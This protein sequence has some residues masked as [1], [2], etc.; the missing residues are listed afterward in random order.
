MVTG[1]SLR[2][3]T[4][5]FSDVSRTVSPL[6]AL[7]IDVLPGKLTSVLGKSGC[8]KTTLLRI[9]GGL[10]KPDEGKV[11][12]FNEEGGSVR[13][14]EIS[15]VFQDPRLL[16]WKTV[17]ENLSLSIRHLSQ[18]EQEKRIFEALELVQL[19]DVSSLY[20]QQLSGGMAQRV[21]LARGIIAR[22]D[23]LLL[24]EPFS[25]LDFMTRSQLQ[26]DFSK[27]QK[28]LGMTMLLVTHDINEAILLSDEIKFMSEGKISKSICI[29]LSKPRRFGD[30]DLLPYQKQLFNFFIS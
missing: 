11:V 21:G 19:G 13:H 2:G 20:P 18:R 4:K 12:F 6:D 14:P 9:V 30:S 3:L 25:A 24:D 29:P 5:K 26:T 22:P 7:D 10:E 27:I 16:A 23:I 1:V 8:G 17:K 28:E 15:L